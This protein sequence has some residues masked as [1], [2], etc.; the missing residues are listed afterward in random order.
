MDSRS[1]WQPHSLRPSLQH[2]GTHRDCHLLRERVGR[3]PSELVRLWG[4]GLVQHFSEPSWAAGRRLPHGPTHRAKPAA[5]QWAERRWPLVAE[6]AWEGLLLADGRLVI[7]RGSLLSKHS[8]ALRSWPQVMAQRNPRNML[9]NLGSWG[10]E[11]P[12]AESPLS[13]LL[14]LG[15]SLLT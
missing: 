6:Q 15:C 11:V 5:G 1:P 13:F 7:A 14:Q 12:G 8:T 4:H 9:E 10:S 2:Q 3:L